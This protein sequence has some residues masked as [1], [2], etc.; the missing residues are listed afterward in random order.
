MICALEKLP[1]NE[2]L[3]Q[4]LEAVCPAEA[5]ALWA[6]QV[7]L[8]HGLSCL[9]EQKNEEQIAAL[10]LRNT[11][12]GVTLA[13]LEQADPEELGEFLQV[14]GW[15]SLTLPQGWAERLNLPNT[16]AENCLVME[17]AETD[18]PMPFGWQIKELSTA[19][20]L[21]NTLSAFGEVIPKWEQEEW[22]WAF[23]LRVRRGFALAAALWQRE[24]LLAAAALCHIGRSAAIIGFVGTPPA[25]RGNGYG[26]RLSAALAAHARHS[27]LRPLLCCR[28]ELE[29]LYRTAGF[30]P[31]GKQ[32][33][34]RPL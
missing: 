9:W 21:E 30:V 10:L 19:K 24:E 15:S 11:M 20:L 32:T 17:W 28:P 3:W 22:Q 26:R 31:I 29:E 5:A 18:A 33:L 14:I 4:R 23:D 6:E 13:L 12:G 25:Q 2:A 27:G 1:Q 8:G 16:A 34:V 7:V